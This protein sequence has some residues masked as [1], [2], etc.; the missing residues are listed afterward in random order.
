MSSEIGLLVLAV[1][2]IMTLILVAKMARPGSPVGRYRRRKLMT[3]NER[4]FFIRLVRALPGHYVF[5]QVSM[6]AL[7][8]ASHSDRKQA[9]A[10]RLRI[11]QQRVDYVVCNAYCDV[12]A[13]VELDDR[14]HSQSKDQLRDARLGQG[15]I[16]TI[17]F[18]SRSKPGTE[19]IRA[20][21]FP[22]EP[23]MAASAPAT[24]AP[25]PAMPAQRDTAASTAERSDAA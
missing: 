13:V 12:I 1:G 6:G 14:T 21:L 17:R 23:A 25:S 2:V 5:P 7:L 8:E 10:D 19:A 9:H 20:A 15:G 11:A 3:E 24:P 18:Q 16:R 4:E 22:E